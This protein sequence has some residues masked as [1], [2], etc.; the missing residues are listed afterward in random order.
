[1]LILFLSLSTFECSYFWS[2]IKVG[3]LVER[4]RFMSRPWKQTMNSVSNSCCGQPSWGCK[5]NTD[6]PESSFYSENVVNCEKPVIN[7]YGNYQ[8]A[9]YSGFSNVGQLYAN[10]A[11]APCQT[12]NP[13]NY[14]LCYSYYGQQQPPSNPC[15]FTQFVDIEDFM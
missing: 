5:C 9:F 15:Q 6:Q 8:R 4:S 11:Y 12:V 3:S 7:N 13:W 2:P 1:M 14:S 10:P